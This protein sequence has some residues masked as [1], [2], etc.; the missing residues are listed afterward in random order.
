MP[1]HG[2]SP[3]P[4]FR[5]PHPGYYDGGY[6]GE[7][8]R[9]PGRFPPPGEQFPPNS[10]GGR[11]LFPI[12][13]FERPTR[14][15]PS[16]SDEGVRDVRL[17]PPR[18]LGTLSPEG[19][20]SRSSVGSRNERERDRS[21]T[22]GTERVSRYSRSSREFEGS[23]RRRGGHELSPFSR[24]RRNSSPYWDRRDRS[25]SPSPRGYRDRRFSPGR[26]GTA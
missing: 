5:P 7:Y 24:R 19:S 3:R 18:Y 10:N 23:P 17:A 8:L 22:R 26:R 9:P 13:D 20:P 16:S 2:F 14:M 15:A 1:A 6:E 25:R 11:P 12:T 4:N 21:P